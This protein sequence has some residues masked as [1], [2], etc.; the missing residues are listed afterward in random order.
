MSKMWKNYAIV[1]THQD[2]S[3]EKL[4]RFKHTKILDL[5]IFRF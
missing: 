3:A 4:I 2:E 5:R 1:S